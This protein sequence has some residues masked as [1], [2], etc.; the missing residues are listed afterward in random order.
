M[1][2]KISKWLL[3]GTIGLFALDL[4]IVIIIYLIIPQTSV[5]HNNLDILYIPIFFMDIF[6]VGLFII[7]TKPKTE[8][9]I[10]NDNK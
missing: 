8:V 10:K 4:L 6:I 1:N 7:I 5:F 2:I 9:T 3:A